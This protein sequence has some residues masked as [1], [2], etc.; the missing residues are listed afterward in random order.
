MDAYTF[1]SG[2]NNPFNKIIKVK[3][4][5]DGATTKL[6]KKVVVNSSIK[7]NAPVLTCRGCG[8]PIGKQYSWQCRS[9]WTY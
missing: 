5:Y 6:T 7:A 3:T 9:G 8:R 4:G 2:I 1:N